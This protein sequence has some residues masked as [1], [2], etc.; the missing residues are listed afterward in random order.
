MTA[1][2][3]KHDFKKIDNPLKCGCLTGERVV[4]SA[5]ALEHALSA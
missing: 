5:G 4:G 1:T 2:E 3:G